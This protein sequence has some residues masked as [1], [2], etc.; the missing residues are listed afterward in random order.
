MLPALALAERRSLE[1]AVGS[2]GRRIVTRGR[3][4]LAVAAEPRLLR[5][6]PG[7]QGRAMA[8][9]QA[10]LVAQTAALPAR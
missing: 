7:V 3:P 6:R 4:A 10:V 5:G 1:L 2:L 9:A 8:E